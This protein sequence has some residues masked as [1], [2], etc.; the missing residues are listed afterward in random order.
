M[1]KNLLKSILSLTVCQDNFS[2]VLHFFFFFFL[3]KAENTLSYSRGQL[4][5]NSKSESEISCVI[6]AI[7]VQSG[8]CFFF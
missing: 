6:I 5:K 2:D 7:E 8:S 4:K 3:T 1:L